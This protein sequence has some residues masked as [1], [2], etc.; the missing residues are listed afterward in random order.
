MRI[1]Q[2]L[3]AS[4]LAYASYITALCPCRKINGCH[5]NQFL[6]SVTTATLLVVHDN[7]FV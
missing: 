4:L 3:A 5:W 6:G 7:V 1:K 2:V